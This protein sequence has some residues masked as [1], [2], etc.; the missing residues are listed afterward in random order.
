MV[1]STERRLENA[2]YKKNFYVDGQKMFCEFCKHV[3]DHTKKSTVDSHLKSDK[4]KN[5]VVNAEKSK[6][7]HQTTLDMA[8]TNISEQEQINIA[9]VNAFTKANIPLEKIDKS[10]F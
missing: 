7:T 3:I 5:N 9:L 2:E 8:V 6:L 1:S 4:H 10:F